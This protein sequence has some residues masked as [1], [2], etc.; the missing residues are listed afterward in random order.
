MP[1][2]WG[3]DFVLGLQA[4]PGD[5]Y[6]ESCSSK[7]QQVVLFF[8]GTDAPVKRRSHGAEQEAGVW[9]Q[10][11]LQAY[12]RIWRSSLAWGRNSLRCGKGMW[13]GRERRCLRKNGLF[14]KCAG[15]SWRKLFSLSPHIQT[16]NCISFHLE[17]NQ[18]LGA[19][20]SHSYCVSTVFKVPKN[21]LT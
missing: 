3:R 18:L 1:W 20:L 6:F 21:Q 8:H 5:P 17:L 4:N 9:A 12:C 16:T 7:R 15:G 10:G 19:S 14:R 2:F 13:E 11:S